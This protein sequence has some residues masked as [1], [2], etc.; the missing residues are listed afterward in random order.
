MNEVSF[1]PWAQLKRVLRIGNVT[2]RPFKGLRLGS[3]GVRTHLSRYF[4]SFVDHNG[5]RTQD[6]TVCIYQGNAFEL[7][8]DGQSAEMRRAVDALLFSTICP[9]IKR[10]VVANNRSVGPPSS[11]RYDL[12]TTRF[13]PGDDYLVIRDGSRTSLGWRIGEIKFPMPFS[14]GGGFSNA[15][16]ELVKAFS[17]L[18]AATG[19]DAAKSRLFRSL[20][21]FRL[22][23]AETHHVSLLSKVVMMGTAFE[24]ILDLPS[25]G[26]KKKPF[27]DYL[28]A[29]CSL[30]DSVEDTRPLLRAGRLPVD[31]V[32]PCISWWAWDFYVLRNDIVHGNM[33]EPERF[34]YE[35]PGRDWLSHLIVADLVFY[36]LVVRQL[37]E[38][39]LLRQYIKDAAR[40]SGDLA[41]Y[42]KAWMLGILD[43]HRAVGWYPIL[44]L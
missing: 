7:L 25:S 4:R 36:E 27:A 12:V 32:Y 15:D 30:P 43:S 44:G 33:I 3:Q 42:R 26:P 16:D 23:H 37:Y 9:T 17:D 13:V 22:A 1:L 2:F 18:E 31:T 24:T 20:E 19:N 41:G 35:A 38:W 14:M 21:W 8:S 6:I 29:Q 5:N 10:G 11:E 39:G 28:K 40:E 34:G